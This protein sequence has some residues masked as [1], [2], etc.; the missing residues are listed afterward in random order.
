MFKWYTHWKFTY[1]LSSLVLLLIIQSFIEGLPHHRQ[2]FHVLYSLVLISGILAVVQ[3]KRMR[4]LMITLSILALIG[5]WSNYSVGG[6]IQVTY[7]LIDR[8]IALT[9]LGIIAGLILREVI[10]CKRVTVDTL[11]GSVCAYLLIAA[12]W[13]ITYSAIE[14]ADANSFRIP[15][16]LNHDRMDYITSLNTWFYYSFMSLTTLGYTEIRPESRPAGT[17]T[18][19]EAVAGQFYLALLV[20]RLVGLH[21]VPVNEGDEHNRQNPSI[22]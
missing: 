8:I 14:L 12:A 18:W 2:I 20:A 9:Y 17:L 5:T 13:G 3:E 4:F 7:I 1:L 10:L 6:N 19:L 16:H 15:A 11:M 22:N 21:T